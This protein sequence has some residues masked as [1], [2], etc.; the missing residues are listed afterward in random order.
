MA[1]RYAVEKELRV[2]LGGRVR[3]ARQILNLGRQNFSE[4]L[5]FHKTYGTKIESGQI[6]LPIEFLLKMHEKFN[7]NPNFIVLGYKP[8][9]IGD[10]PFTLNA[11]LEDIKMALNEDQNSLLK[12]RNQIINQLERVLTNAK[13]SKKA[14]YKK[15]VRQKK[16]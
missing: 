12:Q 16:E 15:V 7:I 13:A 1:R 4:A 8:I 10:E 5:G 14:L 3:E 6:M 11:N 2:K 9:F